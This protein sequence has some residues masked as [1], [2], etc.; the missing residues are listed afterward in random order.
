MQPLSQSGPTRSDA[1]SPAVESL[2]KHEEAACR[3]SA[4][5]FLALQIQAIHAR[6]SHEELSLAC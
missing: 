2:S 4:R 6:A 5:N 3:R 1:D